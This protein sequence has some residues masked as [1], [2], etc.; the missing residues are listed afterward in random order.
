MSFDRVIAMKG[1]DRNLFKVLPVF[2]LVAVILFLTAIT[3]Q[4]ESLRGPA[5]LHPSETAE[6][7][8]DWVDKT[9]RYTQGH[10]NADL[11]ID[12]NQQ[13]YP[14]LEPIIQEYGRVNNLEIALAQG[15]CGKSAGKISRKEVDIAGFCCPP[16]SNDYLP[17]LRF[18][19]LAISPL[20][21]L[22]YPDN[23]LQGISLAEA[24]R[25]FQGEIE[26]WSE[27]EGDSQAIK[28]IASLHCPTRPGH[29]RL[30]L[31]DKDLYSTRLME[32]ED[33]T[34]QISL[35]SS[36]IGAIGY[37][38][39]WIAERFK[40]KGRVKALEIDGVHPKDLQQVVAGAYPLYRVFNVTTWEGSNL[41]KPHALKLVQYLMKQ[42]EG[43]DS[44]YG[45]APASHLK[46]AGWK[47]QNDELVGEPER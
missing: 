31:A 25:I 30:L 33:M 24:R 46:K 1:A 4:A 38:T 34:D 8:K 36:T 11:V 45:L 27:V 41:E 35:I 29:W 32:V 16:G 47:F 23:P 3:S 17:G 18:H 2:I 43:L 21:I 14:I 20:A 7:D 39:L 28:L 42:V 26:D 5:F 15:T 37:E 44:R 9:I 6:M 12:V 40:D 22:T 13:L 19:T 10:Q